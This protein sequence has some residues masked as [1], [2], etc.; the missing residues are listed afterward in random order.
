MSENKWKGRPLS[1][2]HKNALMRFLLSIHPRRQG[3]FSTRG[4]YRWY[5]RELELVIKLQYREKFLE[6]LAVKLDMNQYHQIDLKRIA[7]VPSEWIERRL[8]LRSKQ[9]RRA[10]SQKADKQNS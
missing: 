8:K 2:W 4:L 7:K 5:S 10:S 9:K 3:E 1:E 6:D